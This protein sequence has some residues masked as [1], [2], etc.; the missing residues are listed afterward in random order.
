MPWGAQH[1]PGLEAALKQ[2]SF[3]VESQKMLPLARYQTII[4]RVMALIHKPQS[5][6]TSFWYRQRKWIG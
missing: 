3:V 4:D 5:S 6:G 2:R 1:M